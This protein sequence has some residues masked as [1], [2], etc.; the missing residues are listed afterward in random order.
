MPFQ[1]TLL[2]FPAPIE[3]SSR[4]PITLAPRTLVPFS[5]LQATAHARMHCT[6]TRLHTHIHTNKN[7]SIKFVFINKTQIGYINMIKIKAK[8]N[9]HA[10]YFKT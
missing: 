10:V 1:K 2:S 9:R 8:S 4:T 7:L 5:G 3:G 6:Y